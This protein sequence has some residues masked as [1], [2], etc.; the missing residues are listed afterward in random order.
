MSTAGVDMRDTP[1]PHSPVP[2]GRIVLVVVGTLLVLVGLV[3]GAVGTTMTWA[4]VAQRDDDGYFSTGRHRF[5]AL[6]R[7]ITSDEID[8]GTD[9]GPRRFD[10]G[11]LA[12]VRIQVRPTGD[13]PVFVGIGAEDEVDAYL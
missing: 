3:R 5:E 10:I 8:L 4:H 9:R 6:A 13:G 2:V 1:P 7:A 12:T 11:D